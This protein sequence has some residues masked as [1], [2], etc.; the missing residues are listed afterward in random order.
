LLLVREVNPFQRFYPAE[1][2]L[3]EGVHVDT[4]VKMP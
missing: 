1:R 4:L 2:A 3:V